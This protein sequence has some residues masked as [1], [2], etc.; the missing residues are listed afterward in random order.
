MTFVNYS[1][2]EVRFLTQTTYLWYVN[3]NTTKFLFKMERSDIL[4]VNYIISLPHGNHYLNKGKSNSVLLCI[5]LCPL[6]ENNC[7]GKFLFGLGF[8][9]K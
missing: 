3:I 7:F 2:L 6:V 9:P 1:E 5:L 4:H 8:S